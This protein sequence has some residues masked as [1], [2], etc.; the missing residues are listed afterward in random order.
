M[1]TG[2]DRYQ[3]LIQSRPLDLQRG[4]EFVS[5]NKCGAVN[6]FFGTIRDTDIRGNNQQVQEPIRAIYYE[7]YE[8]MA[9]KQILTI[10]TSAVQS[11]DPV[12]SNMRIFIAIRLGLVPVGDVSI[13]ICASSRRRQTSNEVV[14]S[15]LEQIKSTVVIWKKI[16]FSDGSEEWAGPC[17]SEANWLKRVGS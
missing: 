12:D 2:T 8:T 7:S 10:V 13:I 5:S 1:I 6:S 9:M 3:V 11:N 17:K 14:M 4:F 16:V 15:I